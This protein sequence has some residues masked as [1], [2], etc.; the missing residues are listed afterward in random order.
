MEKKT[1]LFW[2]IFQK[3][4]IELPILE[5]LLIGAPIK[6][7]YKP[8]RAPYISK[9]FFFNLKKFRN[10]NI[11]AS[12]ERDIS[13]QKYSRDTPEMATAWEEYISRV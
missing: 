2:K 4:Y 7:A 9:K 6:I 10:V 1:H 5:V 12:I 8:Y 11:T 3:R 13:E